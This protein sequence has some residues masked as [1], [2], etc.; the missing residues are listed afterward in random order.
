VGWIPV[1]WL[2]VWERIAPVHLLF[3]GV[4]L[5]AST[6]G[7]YYSY[8]H[9]HDALANA[10]CTAALEAVNGAPM[11]AHVGYSQFA[12]HLVVLVAAVAEAVAAVWDIVRKPA[13]R[14]S[15]FACCMY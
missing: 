5:F 9:S 10:N 14:W 4:Y 2:V 3:A 15:N 11:L 8:T 12:L 1:V 6:I 13:R 7:A